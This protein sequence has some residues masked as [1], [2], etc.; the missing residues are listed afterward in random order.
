MNMQR[1]AAQKSGGMAAVEH[2]VAVVLL[3]N[4]KAR[5]KFRPCPRLFSKK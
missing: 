2:T 4:G 1:R 5:V 3:L